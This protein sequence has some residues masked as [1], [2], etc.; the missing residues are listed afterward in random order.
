[1]TAAGA[2]QAPNDD[3]GNQAPAAATPTA[4]AAGA[5][6]VRTEDTRR[7]T[8]VQVV[9]AVQQA[10]KPF[11]FPLALVLAVAAFVVV[12]GRIDRRDPKLAAVAD[13]QLG[14]G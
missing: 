11:A 14:F 12:Q 4:T 6:A 10:A 1:V 13:D 9:R 7:P 8:A 2:D 5:A 3:A